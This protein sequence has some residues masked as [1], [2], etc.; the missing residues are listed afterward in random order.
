M[1]ARALAG[2]RRDPG[3]AAPGDRA[4]GRP[5]RALG[6]DAGE[7]TTLARAFGRSSPGSRRRPTLRRDDGEVV[8]V[9]GI[10]GAGKS[11]LAD[12]Y[13]GAR[14]RA[15]EPRRARRLA[16]R[17]SPTRST[18]SS[19]VRRPPGR[20][21]QHLPHAR[22]AQLRGRG[23]ARGTGCRR[24]ASGSTRRSP[25]RRSTSSSGCSTASARCRPRRAA[26]RWRA[27]SRALLAP[28]SQMRALRELEPPS[29]DE[30]LRGRGAACRSRARRR[31]RSRARRLR[32]GRRAGAARA[33]RARSRRPSPSAPHL[34]F[35]WRPGRRARTLSPPSRRPRGRGRRAGRERRLPARRR[36]ADAAGAGRRCR[37]CRSRSRARTAS[38]RR[39]RS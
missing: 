9:M 11:R 7:R 26:R 3:R 36:P 34:V 12:E 6:L 35:D 13:A 37:D 19:A 33:G 25:R 10:P 23:G 27:A 30:G 24:G 32:R 15:A 14:L 8:L 22:L 4:L 20:A 38:T 39:A 28:T 29:A 31:R 16:P 1:A 17:R 2:R 21:R 18:T 5:R